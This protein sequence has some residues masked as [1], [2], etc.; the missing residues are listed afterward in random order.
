LLPTGSSRETVILGDGCS[1]DISVI[2]AGAL[3][4]FVR[5]AD[6]NLTGTET[7]AEYRANSAAANALERIRSIVA[8][9]IGA[10]DLIADAT[11]CSPD[12]PKLAFVGPAAN[13]QCNDGSAAVEA[14]EIDLVSR[15]VIGKDLTED[16]QEIRIG[17]PSGAMSCRVEHRI[18]NENPKILSAGVTRTARR[19]MKGSVI[20]PNRCF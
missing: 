10:V 13:Y 19:I 16:I 4:V 14:H 20:I 9:K 17:H 2:D 18:S 6:L 7:A 11:H 1:V 15:I 12:V 5:A 8:H 3:Y